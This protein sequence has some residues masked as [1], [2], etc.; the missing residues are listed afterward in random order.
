[1]REKKIKGGGVGGQRESA[2]GDKG[3]SCPVPEPRNSE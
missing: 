3:E 2:R 1:M